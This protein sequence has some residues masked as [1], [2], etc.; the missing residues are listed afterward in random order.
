MAGNPKYH[1]TAYRKLREKILIRD[2]SICQY[3]GQYGNTID[4]IIPL[5]KGG[6]DIEDNLCV[7]CNRCNSGKRDRIAPGSFL[8]DRAKPTTPTGNSFSE[9][10]TERHYFA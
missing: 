4:H 7:A 1:T 9:N 3:C 5:S 2:Q 10:K 8:S 6:L